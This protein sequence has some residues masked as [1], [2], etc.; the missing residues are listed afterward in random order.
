MHRRPV[1]VEGRAVHRIVQ[2]HAGERRKADMIDVA[3]WE[4]LGG[5][6]HLRR[7]ARLDGKAISAGDRRR[8]EQSVD[9]D[10]GGVVLRLLDPE[11]AKERK[12]LAVGL[13]CIDG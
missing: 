5:D 10:R 8:I 4:K 6:I 3:P 9:Y 1:I 13:P 2:K 12:L 11:S 7:L